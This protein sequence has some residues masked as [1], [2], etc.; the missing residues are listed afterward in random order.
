MKWSFKI[1][2]SPTDNALTNLC[3][4]YGIRERCLELQ[5]RNFVI[6]LQSMKRQCIPDAQGRHRHIYIWGGEATKLTEF[7]DVWEAKKFPGH[8]KS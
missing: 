3:K 6:Q 4:F 5:I 1:S 8:E 2:L 7:H